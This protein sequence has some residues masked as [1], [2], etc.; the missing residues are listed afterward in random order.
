MTA[1]RLRRQIVRAREHGWH[2]AAGRLMGDFQNTLRRCQNELDI[3]L[4][5]IEPGLST[6]RIPSALEIYQDIRALQG[7]FEHVEIDRAEHELSVT[8][9]PIV[10]EGIHLGSFQIRLDWQRL[11]SPQPYRVVALEPNPAA[12]NEGV[13][14][15]HVQDE[16]LCE[17]DGRA[18]IRAALT[19]GRIYDFFLLVSQIV[20][21]YGKGSAYVELDRWE[22]VCC[23]DCGT[24]MREDDRYACSR[25]GNTLCEEC[26][27]CCS[28]CDE[29]YCCSCLSTCAE[30]DGEFCR[31]CLTTCSCCGKRVCNSCCE[32]DL[33]ASCQE[34]QSQEEP[35]DEDEDDQTTDEDAAT[36]T[37]AGESHA[38]AEPHSLGK[39]PVSA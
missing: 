37:A 38:A 3:V 19:Q 26:S 13:T 28:G 9:D 20:H 2:L 25:C 10:L 15:P 39:T 23:D 29:S 5:T 7:E 12:T 30:C 36:T 14:H 32:D 16:M 35:D 21:T 33:C 31:S 34:E 24:H 8:T 6:E 27:R 11:G 1:V 17:G 22:G 18:A 4:R